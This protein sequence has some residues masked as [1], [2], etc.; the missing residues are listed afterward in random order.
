M[1]F[2]MPN[3]PMLTNEQVN[4]FHG[5]LQGAL[6]NYQNTVRSAYMPKQIQADIFQKQFAPL[7]QIASNPVAMAMMGD[8]GT[9][10]MQLIQQLLKQSGSGNQGGGSMFGGGGG[11]M[12]GGGGGVGEGGGGMPQ[13]APMGG[14]MGGMGGGNVPQGTQGG[15]G[16]QAAQ[17]GSGE[18]APPNEGGSPQ[19]TSNVPQAGGD[20]ASG[21][22]S[23]AFAPYSQQVYP[24]GTLYFDPK[25]GQYKETTTGQML[26]SDQ[27]G[28]GAIQ[29]TIPML[30]RL[31]E[32][33]KD[34][35]K[36]GKFFKSLTSHIAAAGQSAGIDEKTLKKWGISPEYYNKYIQFKQDQNDAAAR[37]REAYHYGETEGGRATASSIV[38]EGQFENSEAYNKRM[39]NEI[40]KLRQQHEIY[41]K[42]ATGGFNVSP[43]AGVELPAPIR[44][45]P[46]SGGN[47]PE[48][49]KVING[50]QYH[51][52]NGHWVYA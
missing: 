40:K 48:K 35:L 46:P 3:Y 19:S 25:S 28:M 51:K 9:G 10:V 15:Q 45:N 33:S 50:V 6:K 24:A 49:T 11:S 17:G 43:G 13:G 27:V 7:A 38:G 20:L 36:S 29:A 18:G 22:K 16:G 31:Q 14:G 26:S 42:R 8:Q 37:L 52:R 44:E 47:K 4:P 21:V 23:K 32:E 2:T 41:K 5:A 39:E 12:F 34:L 1:A 30:R